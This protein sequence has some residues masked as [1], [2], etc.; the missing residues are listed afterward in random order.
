MPSDETALLR[1]FTRNIGEHQD[2]LVATSSFGPRISNPAHSLNGI[3]SGP[4]YHFSFAS[5]LSLG[6]DSYT[7]EQATLVAGHIL[8]IR[9]GDCF[10]ARKTRLAQVA[11]A[12][13]VVFVNTENTLFYPGW[14]QSGDDSDGTVISIPSVLATWETGKELVRKLRE[15]EREVCV[16]G[17]PREE[18]SW[19]GLMVALVPN[20]EAQT[21]VVRMARA[22]QVNLTEEVEV[23]EKATPS[24]GT[25]KLSLN[26]HV[27]HNIELVD[28]IV[29]RK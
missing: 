28:E 7:A 4:L 5:S 27:I 25:M 9:R 10:F 1:I 23:E 24:K 17:L 2:Y 12:R 14:S 26:G 29:G 11:G 6:C 21:K 18:D 3:V 13:G 20:P 15:W 8:V 22:E 19:V 16:P